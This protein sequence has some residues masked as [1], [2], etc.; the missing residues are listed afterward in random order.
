MKKYKKCFTMEFPDLTAIGG[1]AKIKFD[2][3]FDRVPSTKELV[4]TRDL[5]WQYWNEVLIKK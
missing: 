3:N 4:N 5:G 2:P 1:M